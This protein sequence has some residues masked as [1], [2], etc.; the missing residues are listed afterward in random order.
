M[1]FIIVLSLNVI[2][3]YSYILLA[4]AFMSWVPSLY[5]SSIGKLIVAMVEPVL[6]PFRRL[7]LQFAGLDWTITLVFLLLSGLSEV[8]SRLAIFLLK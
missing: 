7:K 8:I 1:F 5:Q 6:K 2:R 3:I 4:Y